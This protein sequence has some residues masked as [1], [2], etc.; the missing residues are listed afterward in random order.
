MAPVTTPDAALVAFGKSLGLDEALLER[1][2]PIWQ[3]L[4]DDMLRA[5]RVLERPM[6]QGLLGVQGAGKSTLAA[7]LQFLLAREG[8]R[9]ASL[10][11][12]DLYKTHA[13]RLALRARRP[14][15]RYRGPPGT[16]DMDLGLEVLDAL[17][18]G[19]RTHLRL[20]R[21]DKSLCGGSGDR[22]EAEEVESVD[23]LIFEGWFVG[24]RP[25]DLEALERWPETFVDEEDRALARESNA[26]LADYL[27]LWERLD[28]L[29]VLKA[30]DYRLSKTWRE[31]AEQPLRLRGGGMSSAEIEAF[32]DYFWKALHPAIHLEALLAEKDAVDA[33]I[34]VDAARR[35]QLHWRHPAP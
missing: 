35:L 27:P 5:K 24:L 10:S 22:V 34:E 8:C 12:D 2:L 32:I 20:P 7:L 15:L 21:F 6:V 9:V 26:A 11:L 13:E 19:Q 31:Q 33:V 18:Q 25:V 16:H 28:R 4:A 23:I 30:S 14:R 17:R 1:S 29:Y 3:A